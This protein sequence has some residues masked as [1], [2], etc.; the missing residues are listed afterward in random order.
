MGL[1]DLR[2]HKK[3]GGLEFNWRLAVA[4]QRQGLVA[5]DL[6][7]ERVAADMLRAAAIDTARLGFTRAPALDGAF[8]LAGCEFP[9]AAPAGNHRKHNEYENRIAKRGAAVRLQT[10][11]ATH[12]PFKT[13]RM[14]RFCAR[15]PSQLHGNSRPVTRS[16]SFQRRGPLIAPCHDECPFRAKQRGLLGLCL[17]VA[18]VAPRL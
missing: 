3:V 5:L 6:D 16:L 12:H 7:P 10:L 2:H 17:W 11:W 4:E 14:R 18:H 13:C 1:I 9:E 15:G 8:G